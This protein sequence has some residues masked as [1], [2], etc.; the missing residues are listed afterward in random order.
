[1]LGN[2]EGIGDVY[3][4]VHRTLRSQRILA[5]GREPTFP[6][7]GDDLSNSVIP[8]REPLTPDGLLAL[9]EARRADYRVLFAPAPRHDSGGRQARLTTGLTML[10][11]HPWRFSLVF[12]SK[13]TY[14]LKVH[15]IASPAVAGPGAEARPAQ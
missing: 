12:A 14:V 6:L 7:Y 9:C 10:A 2:R 8:A 5:Y 3:A 15:P 4:F 1:M 11:R 13:S